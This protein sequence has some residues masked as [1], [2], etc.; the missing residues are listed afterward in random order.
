MALKLY[1]GF[2]LAILT[3]PLVP[4][5]KAAVPGWFALLPRF[6]RQPS[7]AP[8]IHHVAAPVPVDFAISGFTSWR[9]QV[10]LTGSESRL[11]SIPASFKASLLHEKDRISNIPVAE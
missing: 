7:L 8:I 6:A 10:V 5:V 4:I 2:V 1:K 3:A 11:S 9:M